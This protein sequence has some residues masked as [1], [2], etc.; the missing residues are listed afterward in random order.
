MSYHIWT[1][2][3]CIWKLPII[4]RIKTFVWKLSH[5]K[6]VKGAYL[7]H[8]NIGPQVMC[9]FCSL[10]EETA[11][12][13]IWN[14]PKVS[15]QWHLFLSNLGLNLAI[16]NSLQNGSWLTSSF[17]ARATDPW[18]KA[19]I[20]TLACYIWKERCNLI[21]KSKSPNFNI[22]LQRSLRTCSEFLKASNHRLR[23]FSSPRISQTSISIYT[24]ASWNL[25]SKTAGLGFVI[26]TNAGHI[27][28]ASS[29]YSMMDSPIQAKFAAINLALV[30]CISHNWLPSKIFCDCPGVAQLLKDYNMVIAWRL[31]TDIQALQLSL[32]HF[33]NLSAS[34]IAREDNY[35]ANSLVDHRS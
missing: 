12:H 33:P 4:P 28:L 7:Y 29:N 26:V 34:T 31:N 15:L 8:L 2:W 14:C 35:F 25:D 3:D 30:E 22:L 18:V 10:F 23:E 1:E 24:D 19:T 32:K 5:G 27:L 21:F 16:S 20:S 13:L 11:T 6:L 9:P 17:K